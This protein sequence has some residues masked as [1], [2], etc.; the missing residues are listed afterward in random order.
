M[1]TDSVR[2]PKGLLFLALSLGL[3]AAVSTHLY[4]SNAE[5]NIQDKFTL[6]YLPKIVSARDLKEGSQLTLDD[7]VVREYPTKWM[8]EDS[9]AV[10]DLDEIVGGFLKLDVS[11]GQLLLR[12]HISRTDTQPINTKL[13]PGMRAVSIPVSPRD[14]SADLIS[15]DDKVDL[16]VTFDYVGRRTTTLLLSAVSVLISPSMTA[17]TSKPA[18]SVRPSQEMLTV[19]V[20]KEDAKKLIAAKQDGIISAVVRSKIQGTSLDEDDKYHPQELASMLGLESS[21]VKT[22]L[23][24]IMYGDRLESERQSNREA[25]SGAGFEDV[26][27]E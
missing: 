27:D 20:N 8:V 10:E 2:R 9:L 18:A 26:S 7:L 23:P 14:V 13:M 6:T 5:Q 12:N 11:A 15:P 1:S 22:N 21:P 24:Q 25:I 3:M 4:I 19:A 16:F 17:S